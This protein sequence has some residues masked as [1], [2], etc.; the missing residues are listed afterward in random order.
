MQMQP[1]SCYFLFQVSSRE[2]QGQGLKHWLYTRGE[3]Q[4]YQAWRNVYFPCIDTPRPVHDFSLF[5]QAV[6][7]FSIAETNRARNL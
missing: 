6:P 1:L 3:I 5:K 4:S 2:S 7:E